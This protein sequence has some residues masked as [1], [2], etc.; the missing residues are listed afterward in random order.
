[1][2]EL[3]QMM[4]RRDGFGMPAV[5]H[6]DGGFS[7]TQQAV[8]DRNSMTGGNMLAGM[9]MG[10]Q[11]P[12]QMQREDFFQDR[13]LQSVEFV[14]PERRIN[15]NFAGG[16]SEEPGFIQNFLKMLME[17][18]SKGFGMHGGVRG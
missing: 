7:M 16:R 15:P 1:M 17:D 12:Q 10:Q 6:L 2:N 8:S 9:Q 3:A 14:P 4:R 13:P 5:N 11:Q 18:R